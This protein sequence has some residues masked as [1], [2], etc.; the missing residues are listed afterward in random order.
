MAYLS[1]FK[2]VQSGLFG[3][4]LGTCDDDLELEFKFMLRLVW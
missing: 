2:L 4:P 1:A 3:Q